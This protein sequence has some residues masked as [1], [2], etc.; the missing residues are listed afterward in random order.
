[1]ADM[2]PELLGQKDLKP[3]FSAILESSLG[4]DLW[5]RVALRALKLLNTPITLTT[6][7]SAHGVSA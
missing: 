1:M 5:D 3:H 2:M 4:L 6:S 7:N